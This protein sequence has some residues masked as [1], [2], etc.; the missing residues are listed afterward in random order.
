MNGKRS[1]ILIFAAVALLGVVLLVTTLLNRTKTAPEQLSLAQ[2]KSTDQ[3]TTETASSNTAQ[4][5]TS[6]LEWQ[7][8]KQYEVEVTFDT[9]PNPAPTA[10][11]LHLLFDPDILRVDGIEIGNL[12]TGANILQNS[13]DNETGE[14]MY[15]AGQGFQD[16]VT[17]QTLIATVKVTAI[18][19]NP[20]I[21]QTTLK[22]G[23]E[24]ATASVGIDHLIN[25]EI[26][27]ITLDLKQ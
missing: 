5:R 26:P 23:P 3:K 22:I 15:S 11:T 13:I 20:D 12:W 21:N 24:A 19:T 10:F 25:L 17:N 4:F 27:Q 9:P 1:L 2:E 14:V 8:Q 7:A 6:T 18:N 16:D